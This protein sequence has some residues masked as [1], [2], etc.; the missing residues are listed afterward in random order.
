MAKSATSEILVLDAIKNPAEAGRVSFPQ[1]KTPKRYSSGGMESGDPKYSVVLLF[2]K[3]PGKSFP[4]QCRNSPSPAVMK[5]I[6]LVMKLKTD[7]FGKDARIKEDRL[8]FED[9]D[10]K[11]ASKP[12][13]YGSYKGMIA[14]RFSAR[15]GNVP[16]I[17][18]RFNKPIIDV[19]G[20]VYPGCWAGVITTA[21][22][23]TKGGEGLGLNLLA[24]QKVKD[25]ARLAGGGVDADKYFSGAAGDDQ[26]DDFQAQTATG[27]DEDFWGGPTEERDAF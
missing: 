25:D 23:Y 12:D 7:T 1:L 16:A 5:L 15:E 26:T 10:A 17:R 3:G 27:N 19:E 6:G 11:A 9:G 14:F 4:E 18:N 20:E 22:T 21:W 8:P 2:P 13:T 24:L